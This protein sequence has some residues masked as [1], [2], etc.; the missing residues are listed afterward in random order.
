MGPE[1]NTPPVEL[2]SY[3]APMSIQ[4]AAQKVTTCINENVGETVWMSRDLSIY[5]NSE[6][7]SLPDGSRRLRCSGVNGGIWR[8]NPLSMIFTTLSHCLNSTSISNYFVRPD[9]Q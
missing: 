3:R 2:Y 6:F 5:S 9:G 4:D 8:S 1:I 7:F